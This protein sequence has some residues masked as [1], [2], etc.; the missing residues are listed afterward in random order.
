MFGDT[1]GKIQHD[2]SQRAYDAA[3]TTH[4]SLKLN[5]RYD[6]DIIRWLRQQPSIQG[7]I[8][9]VIREDMARQQKD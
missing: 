9:R 7:Y 8:K 4:F 2:I 6:G 5:D 3:N 1:M